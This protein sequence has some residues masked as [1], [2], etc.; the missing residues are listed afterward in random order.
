MTKMTKLGL[1]ATIA[2]ATLV[3]QA[4]AQ[5]T[6]TVTWN[7]TDG[8]NVADGVTIPNLGNTPTWDQGNNNGTTTE[9]S[10]TSASSGYTGASG[11]NNAGAAARAGALS[12]TA[13]TGSAYFEFTLN[14]GAGLAIEGTGLS[15]GSRS[16]GTGPQLLTLRSSVDGFVGDLA[17]AAVPNTSAWTLVTLSAFDVTGA[18]DTPITFRLYGSNGTGTPSA[19]TANWRTD[20][21][22]FSGATV[23]GSA[24]PEP[25]TY[26]LLGVG[27]LVC[28]QRVRRRT[29]AK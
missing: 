17:T 7:F 20:D 2:L 3:S 11:T 14:P 23:A 29:A 28:A 12:I 6:G 16:T 8:D 24:V 5:G 10:S 19:G 21:I 13:G 18:A 22:T 15:L 4:Y 26:M 1:A 9:I 27:L 25:A